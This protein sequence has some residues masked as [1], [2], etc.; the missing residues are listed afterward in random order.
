MFGEKPISDN[1][2]ESHQILTPEVTVHVESNVP[3]ESEQPCKKLKQKVAELKWKRISKYFKSHICVALR[4]LV[5][6]VQFKKHEQQAWRS[7]NF[8]RVAG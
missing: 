2:E 6:F 5:L 4:A 7:V 8:S 3:N 1:K